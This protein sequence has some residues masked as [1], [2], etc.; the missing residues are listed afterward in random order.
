MSS[1]QLL[2]VRSKFERAC[3]HEDETRSRV[4]DWLK[5][6]PY[7]I[8]G[9]PEPGTDWFVLRFHQRKPYPRK[10][11]NAFADSIHNFRSCLDIIVCTLIENDGYTCGTG[12][13]F[14]AVNKEGDWRSALGS[15]LLNFPA[16]WERVIKDAQP[17]QYGA[18]AT[19]HPLYFLH[20]LDIRSKHRVLLPLKITTLAWDPLL[21]HNRELRAGDRVIQRDMPAITEFKDG[22]EIAA[23]RAVSERNDL[24]IVDVQGFDETARMTHGFG[25]SWPS[26]VGKPGTLF[27]NFRLFVGSLI[28]SVSSAF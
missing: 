26:S 6:Q 19:I 2:D 18:E 21:I 16:A 17:F 8:S 22:I 27:P 15:R 7:G 1:G 14:P 3:Q 24:R 25:P 11:A 10:A 12:H 20:N 4:T 5:G 23:Y 9:K 28:E 13:G